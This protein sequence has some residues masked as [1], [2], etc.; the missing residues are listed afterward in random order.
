MATQ[1]RI[2]ESRVEAMVEEAYFQGLQD[3]LTAD[4]D[5]LTFGEA[6]KRAGDYA[7]D[8]LGKNQDQAE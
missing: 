5:T 2:I 7:R 6:R 4:Q 8:V 3:G 1:K